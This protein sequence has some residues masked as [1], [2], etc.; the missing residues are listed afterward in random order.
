MEITTWGEGVL[1]TRKTRTSWK[2]GGG[3]QAAQ[4]NS[5]H[6]TDFVGP[7]FPLTMITRK[8]VKSYTHELED[9]EVPFSTI[10]RRLSPI[11]TVLNHL[12]EEEEIDIPIPKIKRYKES[13]GRPYFFTRAQFD[14]LR[15][16]TKQTRLSELIQFAVCTG[17]RRA[18]LLTITARDVDL[19]ANLIYF[20]GRPEFNTKTGDWRTVPITDPI[21]H[22]LERRTDGIPK[23]VAIFGDE[24][25]YP[26]KVTTEFRKVVIKN[27]IPPEYVFHCLR[28]SFATWHCEVGTPIRILMDLMGHK[29]LETT[30]RYGKAT[31]KA[32]ESAMSAVFS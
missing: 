6:F 12:V 22:I 32:R 26:N 13:S 7:D 30:L 20:G 1:Y 29:R 2:S 10:N 8:L 21:R 28:H 3:A 27:D 24:W 31:D 15:Q 19:D 17:G 25:E 11:T 9:L 18:E 4:I 5:D 23:D 14:S 16:S